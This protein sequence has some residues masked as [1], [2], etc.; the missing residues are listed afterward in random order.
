VGTLA[1]LASFIAESRKLMKRS[2]EST[3]AIS[4]QNGARLRALVDFETVGVVYVHGPMTYGVRCSVKR[5][6]TF[7]VDA[8]TSPLL[9]VVHAKLEDPAIEA[10]F[11]GKDGFA[12]PSYAGLSFV[13][14]ASGVGQRFELL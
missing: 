3:A 10:G 6:T 12:S 14:D 2:R 1:A 9:G 13:L 4:V 8:V 5:G 7:L 11:V